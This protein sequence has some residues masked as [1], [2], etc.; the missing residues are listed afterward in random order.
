MFLSVLWW[1]YK[2]RSANS[3][4]VCVCARVYACV[5]QV[6]A[7]LWRWARLRL[8]LP[9]CL[10]FNSHPQLTCFWRVCSPVIKCF[11]NILYFAA[12]RMRWGGV[13]DGGAKHKPK[14]PAANLLVG[15]KV[16]AAA[17]NIGYLQSLR[18]GLLII[19]CSW[20]FVIDMPDYMAFF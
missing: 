5:T 18:N 20:A 16:K 7:E 6:L 12:V 17:E 10:P 4:C 19:F 1:Q 3:V 8:Q 13:D 11:C 2:Y 14:F 15:K 9:L